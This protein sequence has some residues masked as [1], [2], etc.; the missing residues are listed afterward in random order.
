MMIQRTRSGSTAKATV[1]AGN[2]MFTVESS[3]TTKAPLAAI[4][5][6]I[7]RY[8]TRV[9]PAVVTGRASGRPARRLALP[10]RPR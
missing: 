4:H 7:A 6:V 1:I 8:D 9:M 5:R 10:G 2:A 3:E